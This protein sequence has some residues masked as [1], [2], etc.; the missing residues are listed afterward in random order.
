MLEAGL[1]V[2]CGGSVH[3]A[4]VLVEDIAHIDG[5]IP[6][7]AREHIHVQRVKEE[8]VGGGFAVGTSELAGKVRCSY[9]VVCAP[10]AR[11]YLRNRGQIEVEAGELAGV[12][13]VEHGVA[14]LLRP[15]L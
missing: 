7:H 12:R 15:F 4:I 2:L 8:P 9:L 11:R 14:E 13:P 1:D 10:C 5:R 3:E 6:C